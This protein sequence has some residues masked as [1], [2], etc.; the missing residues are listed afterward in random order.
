MLLTK[1]IT[2]DR[3]NPLPNNKIYFYSSLA[4]SELT[5][6]IAVNIDVKVFDVLSNSTCL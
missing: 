1:P 5:D 6:E 2:N 4:V 3:A